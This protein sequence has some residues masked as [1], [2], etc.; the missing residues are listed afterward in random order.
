[1]IKEKIYETPESIKIE[2]SVAEKFAEHYEYSWVR[3][4]E[5]LVTPD[6][7]Y[8]VDSCMVGASETKR[9]YN[10]FGLYDD[11]FID[12]QKVERLIEYGEGHSI[13]VI[14]LIGFDDK[15]A[16][17]NPKTPIIK[18]ST[19]GRRNRNPRRLVHYRWDDFKIVMEEQYD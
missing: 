2:D 15:I 7:V 1:M 16:Y 12:K 5:E 6:H 11:Y 8:Y 18:E 13:K 10:K 19:G 9:R 14:I 17:L 4:N 3:H